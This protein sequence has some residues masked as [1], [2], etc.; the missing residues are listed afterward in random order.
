VIR[1]ALA[2]AELRLGIVDRRRV[3]EAA[4]IVVDERQEPAELEVAAL[5]QPVQLAAAAGEL[6]RLEVAQIGRK[7]LV[8]QGER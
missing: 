5:A 1:L 7:I 4:R 6:D 2:H 8:R 3:T